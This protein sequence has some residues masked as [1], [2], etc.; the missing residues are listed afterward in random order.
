MASVRAKVLADFIESTIGACFSEGGVPSAIAAVKALGCWP[1]ITLVQSQIPEED[2]IVA[3]DEVA[4]DVPTPIERLS[5]PENYPPF[6]Q[7]IANLQFA[8]ADPTST[9]LDMWGESTPVYVSA[10]VVDDLERLLGYRFVNMDILEEAVTHCS[11]PY[12]RSNQRME[13]L[14]DA[15]LDFAVVTILCEQYEFANE[16][17]LTTLKSEYTNNMNLGIKAINLGLQK[18]LNV[19]SAHLVNDFK[20]IQLACEIGRGEMPTSSTTEPTD[21][22]P[23]DPEAVG[24]GCVKSLADFLEALFGAI[25]LDCGESLDVAC[26]VVNHIRLIPPSR[27][28]TLKK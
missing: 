27:A 25:F 13:F 14:G 2:G 3:K 19:M 4:M 15:V 17:E 8:S 22:L 10:L 21:E 11:I 9:D 24:A 20:D 5:V 16:G 12:R 18:Y 6:L 1:T 26:K 28:D 23:F 7:R